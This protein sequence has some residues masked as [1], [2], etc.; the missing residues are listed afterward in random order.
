[1]VELVAPDGARLTIRLKGG[2][3]DVAA[4]VNAFREQR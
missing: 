3:P 1:M 2:S 4:L